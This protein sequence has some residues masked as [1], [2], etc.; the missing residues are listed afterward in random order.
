MPREKI[1]AGLY[2]SVLSLIGLSWFPT[3]LDFFSFI[4]PKKYHYPRRKSTGKCQRGP[5]EVYFFRGGLYIDLDIKNYPRPPQ[6]KILGNIYP[7]LSGGLLY[8]LL[9]HR[10]RL[11]K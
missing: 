2:E 8:A 9:G 7:V 6:K 5:V 11:G 3:I 4:T 1:N 10:H